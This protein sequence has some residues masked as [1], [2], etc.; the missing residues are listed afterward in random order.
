MNVLIVGKNSYIGAK[1]KAHL[2]QYGHAVHEADTVSDEW[3]TIDYSGY[4]AVVHVAAIVHE[5][6]KT[7]SP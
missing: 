5:D 6:A 7:A 2:E 4:D 1:T 3:Q